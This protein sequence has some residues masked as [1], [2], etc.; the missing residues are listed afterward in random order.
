MKNLLSLLKKQLNNPMFVF[1]VPA[2]LGLICFLLS[3]AHSDSSAPVGVIGFIGYV[4]W[5]IMFVMFF[6]GKYI[7]EKVNGDK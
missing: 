2:I 3:P 7:N 4:F 5:G 6:L 1:G